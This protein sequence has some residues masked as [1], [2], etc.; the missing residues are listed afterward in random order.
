[1]IVFRPKFGFVAEL[2]FDLLF[3]F[4]KPDRSGDPLDHSTAAMG[5]FQFEAI[6]L[7]CP[8]IIVQVG[9]TA[10]RF[11]PSCRRSNPLSLR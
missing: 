9:E 7:F 6:G 10:A 11:W 3:F 4:S 8:T 5:E 1:L 2:C